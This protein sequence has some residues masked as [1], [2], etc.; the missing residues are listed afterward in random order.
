MKRRVL[1]LLAVFLCVPGGLFADQQADSLYKQSQA[2]SDQQAAVELLCKAAELDPATY[3]KKCNDAKQYLD[4]RLQKFE[5][6]YVSGKAKFEA[7]QY[8]DAI[9]DLSKIYFGPR[10]ADAQQ[11]IAQAN[12]AINHPQPSIDVTSATAL[13][14]AQQAFDNGDFPT[15]E[16][17]AGLVKAPDQ[18]PQAQTILSNIRNYHDDMQQAEAFKADKNYSAAQQKYN[19]ALRIKS[20]GPG[21]PAGKLAGLASLMK[22]PNGT[23]VAGNKPP[24]NS[25]RINA[26]LADARDHLAKSDWQGALTACNQV[27]TLDPRQPEALTCREKAQD[28]LKAALA[29]DPKAL[30]DTLVRGVRDYYESHLTDA[31]DALSLYLTA[32]GN[33]SKGAAYFYLGATMLSQAIL[34]SPKSKEERDSLQ[35]N[36]IQQFQQAKQQGFKPMEKNVSPKILAVWNQP[37][38]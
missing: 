29:S 8:T 19:D 12:D 16:T 33:R 25:V 1:L 6:L 2:T 34:S 27:L 3:G 26:A 5:G 20:N 36:A 7:K 22:Q 11:L 38:M 18:L 21:D 28:G 17:N 23:T 14:A 35:Q 4:G 31:R 9:S 32:G 24:D 15:A 30:E 13:K 10:H 37:G